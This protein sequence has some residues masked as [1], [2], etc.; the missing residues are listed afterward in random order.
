M[1]MSTPDKRVEAVDLFV[2]ERAKSAA[3]EQTVA[4]PKE[5]IA[6]LQEYAFEWIWRLQEEPETVSD[7]LCFERLSVRSQ[8][9]G[10]GDRC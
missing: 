10:N 3:L 5:E 6:S 1:S 9:C 2:I 7:D 4:A 8:T